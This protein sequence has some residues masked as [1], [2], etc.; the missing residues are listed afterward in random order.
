[1]LVTDI[2]VRAGF[3]ILFAFSKR[4]DCY[5]LVGILI[6]ENDNLG[7]VYIKFCVF[8]F[9]FEILGTIFVGD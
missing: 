2:S 4:F 3:D 1:M 5:F 8:I 6:T 7:A 9:I